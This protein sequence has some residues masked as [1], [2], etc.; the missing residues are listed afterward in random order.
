MGE[1]YQYY[2]GQCTIQ[3]LSVATIAGQYDASEYNLERLSALR[4]SQVQRRLPNITSSREEMSV[5]TET[6][7][8]RVI[9]MALLEHNK[10][11]KH[12]RVN[13]NPSPIQLRSPGWVLV[14]SSWSARFQLECGSKVQYVTEFIVRHSA[15]A[16]IWV[17]STWGPCGLIRLADDEH[18][19]LLSYN[20]TLGLKSSM[21]EWRKPCISVIYQNLNDGEALYILAIAPE[22]SHNRKMA[23]SHIQGLLCYG[24]RVKSMCM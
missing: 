6:E 15:Y 10:Q 24:V 13:S 12:S 1:L 14:M 5:M 8:M 4:D 22:S 23:L 7:R 9:N 19:L 17:T 3:A 18:L 16:T 20:L 21:C 11:K 2:N